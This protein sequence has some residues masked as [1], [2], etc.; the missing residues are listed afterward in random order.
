MQ[1]RRE[2]LITRTAA[3]ATLLMLAVGTASATPLFATQTGFDCLQCH[4]SPP[5]G[6]DAANDLTSAGRRFKNSGFN[7]KI[8]SQPSR[9]AQVC[10]NELRRDGSVAR[11]CSDRGDAGDD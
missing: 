8:F 2:V 6:R 9:P 7:P 11:V 3:T 5:T 1:T 10:H 4:G